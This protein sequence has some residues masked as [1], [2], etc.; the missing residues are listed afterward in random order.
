AVTSG[1]A[2]LGCGQSVCSVTATGD[3]RA[4]MNVTAVDGAWSIVTASL[5]NGSGLQAQFAGGTPP[6]IAALTPQLS[7]AAGASILWTVQAL[8]EKNGAPLAG[9]TVIWKPGSGIAIEGE[10]AATTSAGGIATQILAVGPLADE[11]QASIQACV[12]GT[13]QCATFT[14][15]GSRPEYASLQAVSGT[16][17]SLSVSATPGQIVLRVLDM[18]GNP[19]AGATVTLNQALYAWTP[20]CAP[21][22]ICAQGALLARQSGTAASAVDGTVT[23]VPASLPGVATD[24]VGLAASGNTSTLAIAIEQH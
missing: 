18:D 5:T 3:G 23:F 15:F 16:S 17:Q 7:L 22:A 6:T 13:N 12:N 11:Q 8:V 24:L 1:T 20:P 21:H 9:Q 19:M 14:A 10:P 2:K 4:T